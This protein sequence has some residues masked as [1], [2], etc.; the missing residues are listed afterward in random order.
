MIDLSKDE[1]G[2]IVCLSSDDSAG[3]QSS[4]PKFLLE[5]GGIVLT[6]L[7]VGALLVVVMVAVSIW[8][9]SNSGTFVD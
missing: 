3:T 7:A 4:L 2:E 5:L 1:N 9:A 8:N 6:I